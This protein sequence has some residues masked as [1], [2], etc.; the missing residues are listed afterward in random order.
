MRGRGTR[1]RERERVPSPQ[2]WLFATSCHHRRQ[3][4]LGLLCPW[5][6]L[7][8]VYCL[9]RFFEPFSTPSRGFQTLSPP[10][11]PLPPGWKLRASRSGSESGGDAGRACRHELCGLE[12][13]LARPV[14]GSARPDHRLLAPCSRPRPPAARTAPPSRRPHVMSSDPLT[15]SDSRSRSRRCLPC[16]T[17]ISSLYDSDVIP[18]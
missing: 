16:T 11:R 15:E 8:Q 10:P 18:M 3:A 17:R 5:S 7:V 2:P 9:L 12:A 6:T 13:R 4:Q 14:C 1:R